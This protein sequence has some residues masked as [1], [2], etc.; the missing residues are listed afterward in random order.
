MKHAPRSSALILT[1]VSPFIFLACA[2]HDTSVGTKIDDTAITTQ[3][4]TQLLAD[5]DVSGQKVSVDTVD[6]VVQLSGFVASAAAA[7]RAVEIARSVSGVT[8]VQNNITVR[9]P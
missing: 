9:A 4:K 8:S 3:V 7:T 2:T 1:L 5:P 6:G